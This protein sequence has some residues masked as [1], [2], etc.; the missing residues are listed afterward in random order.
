MQT[1]AKFCDAS[2][3]AIENSVDETRP[4]PKPFDGAADF[5]QGCPESCCDQVRADV[6]DGEPDDG[7]VG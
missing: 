6:A 1:G 7:G 4:S 2:E 5:D 3:L